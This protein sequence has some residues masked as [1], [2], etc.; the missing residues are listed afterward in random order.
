M[1]TATAAI[2]YRPG[3]MHDQR[4]QRFRHRMGEDG[5]DV[6]VLVPGPNLRYLTGLTVG[7]SERLFLGVVPK[8]GAMRLLVPEL[9]RPA[10]EPE[11]PAEV[12]IVSH[13]D[14]TGPDEAMA[15]LAHELGLGNARVGVEYGR[16]RVRE[17]RALERHADPASIANLDPTAMA[18]RRIKDEAEIASLRRAIGLSEAFLEAMV[19]AMEPGV[20]EQDVVRAFQRARIES[21]CEAVP[22]GPI[23]AS[24]PNTESPH[25]LPGDRRLQHGDIVTI[26]CGAVVDGYPGDI[27]RNVAVGE[28]DPERERI[29]QVVLDANEAGRD[30]CRPGATA[31]SVD[32]AARAV[33]EDAG[34]GESFLHRTGHGMGLEVHEPPD[35]MAGNDQTLEPGMVFT[36][37]PG[38]YVPGVGGARVED[39]MLITHDGAESLT[40]YPRELARR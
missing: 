7:P 36:V 30:A 11:V 34:Y 32:R 27:T 22:F 16:M 8:D 12:P 9:E 4:L 18:L 13:R 1:L 20:T 17:L 28:L 35:I 19:D 15:Q 3:V 2:P 31:E 33:I 37:E 5:L 26:D 6:A 29:H 24:G 25:A 14:E 21:E 10:V 23:V 38:V 40:Q 39:D